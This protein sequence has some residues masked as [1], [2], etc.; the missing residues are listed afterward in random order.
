V[1]DYS[2]VFRP[3]DHVGGPHATRNST[4][5][6]YFSDQG[7]R[8]LVRG[9]IVDVIHAKSDHTAWRPEPTEAVLE[10][11]PLVNLEV[12]YEQTIRAFRD[13]HHVLVTYGAL[14]IYEDYDSVLRAFAESLTCGM[15]RLANIEAGEVDN[16]PI[17]RW[18]LLLDENQDRSAELAM[19]QQQQIIKENFYDNPQR[20]HL[21]E[22]EEWQTLC[23]LKNHPDAGSIQHTI[24]MLM[25]DKT[26]FVTCRGY[27]GSAHSSVR[28][29]DAIFLLEGVSRPMILRRDKKIPDDWHVV[30]PAHIIG[31]ME[32]ELWDE[33]MSL[34]EIPIV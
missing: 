3:G 27:I 10:D 14:D 18:L 7:R 26:F 5:R 16:G 21:T 12:G 22:S 32:G 6:F 20:R 33:G 15:S 2:E 34:H 4:S 1:P 24:W 11:G 23:M 9:T 19:A 31:M 29:D 28:A 25:R 30:C 13:W 17:C 8:L